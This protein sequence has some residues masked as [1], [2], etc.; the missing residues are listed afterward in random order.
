MSR[1]LCTH[2]LMD[3]DTVAVCHYCPTQLILMSQPRP[4]SPAAEAFDDLWEPDSIREGWDFATLD[5]V[6]PVSQGGP[7][8]LENVVLSCWPCNHTKGA[9][10]PEQW[11]GVA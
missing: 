5:H 7:D 3:F 2:D 6:I 8:V 11:M 4:G 9:R 1:R 10:T